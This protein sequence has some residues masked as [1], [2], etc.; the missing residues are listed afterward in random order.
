MNNINKQKNFTEVFN[1]G[2]W[3]MVISN[4]ENITKTNDGVTYCKFDLGENK[5]RFWDCPI[6]RIGTIQEVLAV[7]KC[8]EQID[9]EK[10]F[11]SLRDINKEVIQM[12]KCFIEILENKLV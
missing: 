2:N 7:L 12:E 8:W 5:N 11:E 1:S 6:D 9:S 10:R 3:Y 4:D